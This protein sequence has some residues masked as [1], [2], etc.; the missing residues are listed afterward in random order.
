MHNFQY[1]SD[2]TE[3]LKIEQIISYRKKKLA[4]QQIVFS[5]ILTIL[6]CLLAYYVFRKMWYA[7]FDGYVQADYVNYKA[8]DDLYLLEHYKEE[9]DIVMPGDTLYSYIY[10]D[11][12]LGPDNRYSEPAVVTGDR[13][14]RL[15]TGVASQ[16]ANV[17]RVRIR[18][19]RK[20]IEKEDHNIQFGLTDNSHKMDLQRELAE[21]EEQLKAA[22]RKMSVYYSISGETKSAL[23]RS[24]LQL[25]DNRDNVLVERLKNSNEVRYVLANDT[26]VV[27]KVWNPAEMA[28]FKSDAVVQI[29]Y[30]NL[31]SSNFRVVA[32]VPT[33]DMD[34]V[35]HHTRAEVIVNDDVHFQARVKLLGARTEDL[36]DELR[37]SLSRIY[38]AV[39][40]VFRPDSAQTLPL[41]AVVDRVPVRIRINKFFNEGNE[42]E[43]DYW[44]INDNG[45]TPRTQEKIGFKKKKK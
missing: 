2:T 5:T 42:Y 37:N 7:E 22:L 14:I 34:K 32:Y 19:L 15:Q 11:N 9:G 44:Y 28:V 17:L 12:I 39:M 25:E 35:N 13:N 8:W 29:Q 38:T 36:P 41:W 18:E 33:G 45:L 24:G 3:D 26:A 40:V 21:T 31:K 27:T 4:R 10:L 20:Q 6:L 43:D 30:L 16:D 23:Q 1:D